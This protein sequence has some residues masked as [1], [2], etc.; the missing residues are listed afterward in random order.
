MDNKEKIKE[1]NDSIEYWSS[2]LRKTNYVKDQAILAD[3]IQKARKEISELS[4]TNEEPKI[5]HIIDAPVIDDHDNEQT[6]V[7]GQVVDTM[8][9]STIIL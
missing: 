7:R 6:L 3:K 8:G 9:S 1:L 5:S 4:T 2:Q